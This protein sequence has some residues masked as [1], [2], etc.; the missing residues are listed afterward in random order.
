MSE[1]SVGT[2]PFHIFSLEFEFEGFVSLSFQ[3]Q[4]FRVKQT[5][6]VHS[7][8]CRGWNTVHLA[9]K[10][11]IITCELLLCYPQLSVLTHVHDYT[12]NFPVLTV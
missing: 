2:P 6:K 7:D 9:P 5:K 4:L 11:S 1:S 3:A 10:R 8:L 12:H